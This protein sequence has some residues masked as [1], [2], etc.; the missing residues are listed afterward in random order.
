MYCIIVCVCVGERSNSWDRSN[1]VLL[2]EEG[3]G[4]G[5]GTRF[6]FKQRKG[7][8]AG[9]DGQ[10]IHMGRGKSDMRVVSRC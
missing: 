4:G 2:G 7:G 10:I 9:G 5:G 1:R 3:G 6:F 8:R